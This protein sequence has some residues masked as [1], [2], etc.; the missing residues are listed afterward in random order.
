MPAKVET[1]P[2]LPGLS[3]VGGRPLVARFGGGQLS[4]DEG[5]LTL[6]EIKRRLAIADRLAARLADPLQSSRS[7]TVSPTSS[8]SGC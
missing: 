4:S 2:P 3:P 6:R 8:A 7:S 1:T 5:V